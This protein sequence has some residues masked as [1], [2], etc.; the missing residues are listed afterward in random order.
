MIGVVVVF[1]CFAA[2]VFQ[3]LDLGIEAKISCYFLD[4]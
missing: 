2:G 3:I 1:F 4:L